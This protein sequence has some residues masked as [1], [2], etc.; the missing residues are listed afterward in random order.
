VKFLIIS[1]AIAM[2]LGVVL[3]AF[4]AHGLKDRLGMEMIGVWQTAVQYHLLHALG[5]ILLGIL[6]NQNPEMI[7]LKTAGLFL[8]SGILLF[9]GSLYILAVA[10]VP[11]LGPV[12]PFGGLLFITGWFWVAFTVFRS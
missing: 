10:N 1:G 11:W 6:L 4:G 5:L 8:L 12:T 3:G 7:G 9:S 2:A